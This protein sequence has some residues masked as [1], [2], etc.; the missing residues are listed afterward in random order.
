MSAAY[1]SFPQSP[2]SD[3]V[4]QSYAPTVHA[5]PQGA[6]AQQELERPMV[7]KEARGGPA[8]TARYRDVPFALLFLLQL[9]AVAIVAIAN[10]KRVSSQGLLPGAG[11]MSA[12]MLRIC[13]VACV[14][15]A[16]FA[17]CWLA[18]LRRHAR[19][20]IWLSAGSSVAL[21]A[22]TAIWLLT[23]H[24][25]A[26][27]TVGLGL[28]AMAAAQCYYL[29]CV[30]ERVAFSAVLLSTV[31]SLVQSHPA[32]LTVALAAL[33][34]CVLWIVVWSVAVA[35]TLHARALDVLRPSNGG[36]DDHVG[37]GA[38]GGLV[39]LLVV[40]FYWTVHVV[41]N[42][43]HVAVAGTVG[44][45]YFLSPQ[46]SADPTKRSLQRALTTSFG[47]VCLGSLVVSV[48]RALR[49]GASAMSRRAGPGVVRSCLLCALGFLDVLVRFFNHY[50]FT[51]VALYGKHFTSASR[52]CW[53]LLVRC[54]VDV[55][56][57]KDMVGSVLAMGCLVGGLVNA[58]C[59]GAW[60]RGF[61]HGDVHEWLPTAGLVFMIGAGAQ[62]LVSSVVESAVSALYVCYAEDPNALATVN[63]EL[64][65]CFVN[66][67][68]AVPLPAAQE[69][70]AAPR[71]RG[72][73]AQAFDRA[74]DCVAWHGP[75]DWPRRQRPWLTTP[76]VLRIIDRP[77]MTRR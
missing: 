60:A 26:A 71:A 74:G 47:S 65:A 53:A 52:D 66:A 55:L 22:A 18:L 31:A 19:S 7:E 64:Y 62:L 45:W 21:Y 51:H 11:I 63:P 1:E 42:V 37:Y 67:N 43:V 30:R 58:L 2:Q 10:G 33:V 14:V 32:M 6:S 25:G 8:P 17:T 57:Q 76:D 72:P 41:K 48:I 16:V 35:C 12:G 39:F 3:N 69:E 20:L 70:G 50:A 49:L 24:H 68:H 28:L 27:T 54:G 46:A 75:G 9:V 38:Q 4:A 23:G 13:T 56:V 15:S 61:F 59:L 34:V 36:G 40:S 29:Y 77:V 5:A 44:S 73:L